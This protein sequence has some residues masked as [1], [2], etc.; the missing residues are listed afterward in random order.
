MTGSKGSSWLDGVGIAR[1]AAVLACRSRYAGSTPTWSTARRLRIAPVGRVATYGASRSALASDGGGAFKWAVERRKVEEREWH[2]RFSEGTYGVAG[3]AGR[4]ICHLLGRRDTLCG[5]R[6]NHWA[7]RYLTP[8]VLRF[9]SIILIV[10]FAIWGL[11][12]LVTCAQRGPK[13]DQ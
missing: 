8:Y 10:A 6:W 1:S 4:R 7:C 2:E 13:N 9:V 3:R 11:G 5:G 12:K